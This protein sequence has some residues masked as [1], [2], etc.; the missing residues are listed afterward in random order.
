MPPNLSSDKTNCHLS[1]KH[2]MYFNT[3]F[4]F[5]DVP[6][7]YDVNAILTKLHMK[8]PKMNF[9]QYEEKLMKLGIYYLETANEGEPH[10]YQSAAV[11]MT[12]EAT[13]LFRQSVST[14]YDKAR[15]AHE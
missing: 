11:G 7:K 14:E 1:W 6:A 9:F 13:E 12:L 3:D 10:F 4:K 5:E 15:L 8:Y 2:A